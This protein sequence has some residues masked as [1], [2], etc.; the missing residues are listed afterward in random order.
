[1][2]GWAVEV[3]KKARNN[4]PQADCPRPVNSQITIREDP[5]MLEK[6]LW[7]SCGVEFG[8]E[9]ES[10][11]KKHAIEHVNTWHATV[12][13]KLDFAKFARRVKILIYGMNGA[14]EITK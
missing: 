1:M 10:A 2:D 3:R 13:E 4:R 6:Y 12:A 14:L 9:N 5:T 7:C 8:S 11:N